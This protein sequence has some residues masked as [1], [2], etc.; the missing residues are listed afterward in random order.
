MSG[1]R[2]HFSARAGDY[3]RFRPSYPRALVEHLAT[4][5]PGRSL[6]WDVGTGSGQAALALA[7]L[8]DHVVATDASAE[9]IRHAAPHFA[10]TYAQ[11]REGRSG[12]PDASADLVTAAQAAHWFDLAAFY[13][14][15]RRV[16]R[17]GGVVAL[18]CYGAATCTHPQVDAAL[19]WFYA[20]RGGRCGPP[21]RAPPDIRWRVYLYR[22]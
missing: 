7:D 12:L 2:D 18:W 19:R 5:A 1:F 9:Q 13:A 11:A 21:E 17:P 14:E 4:L 20:E 3:A 15:V 10:V 6:A 16:L 8:F 22:Q